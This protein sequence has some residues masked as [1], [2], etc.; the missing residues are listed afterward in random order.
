VIDDQ[1]ARTL[2]T[3]AADPPGGPLEAPIRE[4]LTRGRA[5]QRRRRQ[6]L[7]AATVVVTGLAITVPV[8][9]AGRTGQSPAPT[10]GGSAFNYPGTGPGSAAAL[11][12][13]HWSRLPAAPIPG[14]IGQATVWTGKQMLVWGGNTGGRRQPYRSDGAAYDPAANTWSML[15]AAPLSARTEMASVWTGHDM[16]IWGGYYSNSHGGF[17]EDRDGALYNPSTHQWRQLPPAPL[18]PRVG[19]TALWTGSEVVLIGGEPAVAPHHETFTDAAAYNP[20]TNTW[21]PLPAAPTAHHFRVVSVVA[22]AAGHSIYAWLTWDHVIQSAPVGSGR[23]GH[24]R[25]GVD[26]DRYDASTGRWTQVHAN[27]DVPTGVYSPVWTGSEIVMPAAQLCSVGVICP[28]SDGTLGYRFD[29]RRNTWTAIARGPGD[30]LHSDAVWTG[31]AL[32]VFNNDSSARGGGAPVGPINMEVWAPNANRWTPL[33]RAPYSGYL[34]NTSAVWAGDR[35][36]MWG[37]LSPDLGGHQPPLNSPD[38]VGLSYGG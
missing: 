17:R 8:M 23:S 24:E 27:G 10:T 12:Q 21:R 9:L 32:L 6:M 3:R 20:T 5:Q 22:I 28:V 1:Q 13:G 38:T 2:L 25:L 29:P 7:V 16:F 18:S 31:R 14:R 15:P 30:A 37:Q 33:P 35:L 11:E 34:A 19:A 36:L 4:L 26:V